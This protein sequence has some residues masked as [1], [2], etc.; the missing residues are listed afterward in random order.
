MSRR[1]ILLALFLFLVLPA[2]PVSAAQEPAPLPEKAVVRVGEHPGFSRLVLDFG[3]LPPY[4]SERKGNSLRIRFKAPV[5]ILLPRLKKGDLKNLRTARW[6]A[7]TG[8]FE[9]VTAP[10]APVRLWVS[11]KNKLVIDIYAPVSPTSESEAVVAAHEASP[12][13]SSGISGA[14][15]SRATAEAAAD[16]AIPAPR[17]SESRPGKPAA[18]ADMPE[19]AKR[20]ADSG[21]VPV[22]AGGEAVRGGLIATAMKPGAGP[23]LRIGYTRDPEGF[24]LL[25]ELPPDIGFAAFRRGNL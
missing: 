2:G 10:G 8:S 17:Q 18:A 1:L 14:K 12:S 4:E 3:S 23:Q 25:L 24:A 21:T 6:S 20:G 11:E 7:R 15:S 5:T 9:L 22:A 13:P 16:H 19:P